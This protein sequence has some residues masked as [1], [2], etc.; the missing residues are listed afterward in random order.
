[1]RAVFDLQGYE[2]EVKSD[3]GGFGQFHLRPTPLID[4]TLEHMTAGGPSNEPPRVEQ[5]PVTAQGILQGMPDELRYV[6]LDR[7][8]NIITMHTVRLAAAP[9]APQPS[10]SWATDGDT[11][12]SLMHSIA[13]PAPPADLTFYLKPSLLRAIGSTCMGAAEDTKGR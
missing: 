9:D 8:K 6:R 12:E 13:Q 1:M 3:L 10:R 2:L 7:L 11:F 4:H 5:D